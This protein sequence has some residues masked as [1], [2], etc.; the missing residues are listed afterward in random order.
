MSFLAVPVKGTSREWLATTWFSLASRPH[1]GLQPSTVL[2]NAPPLARLPPISF[3]MVVP[4]LPCLALVWTTYLRHC[5]LGGS[6]L[7]HM[8]WSSTLL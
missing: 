7:K 6:L 8:S 4:S 5:S 1:V 2:Y 3:R